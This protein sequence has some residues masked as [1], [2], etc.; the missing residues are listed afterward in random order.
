MATFK[1]MTW[2]VCGPLMVLLY[3]GLA[4]WFFDGSTGLL[5]LLIVPHLWHT[6]FVASDNW[7]RM[8]RSLYPLWLAIIKDGEVAE[9]IKIRQ[10]A[11]VNLTTIFPPT[12]RA[13]TLSLGLPRLVCAK[14]QIDLSTCAMVEL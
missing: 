12:S 5:T 13:I 8:V 14:D 10:K 1:V 4:G 9:L 7:R 2:M 11:K 3:A 6:S